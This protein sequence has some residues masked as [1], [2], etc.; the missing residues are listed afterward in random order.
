MADLPDD[1]LVLAALRAWLERAVIGL[2]L[3]P[4]AKG[5]YVK[6]QIHYAVSHATSNAQALD[7]LRAELAALHAADAQTR[8]TTLLVFPGLWP[9]FLEFNAFLQ[10]AQRALRR[11]RLEGVLQ[12][13]SFHPFYQ[14]ADS[15]HDDPANNSNRAPYPTLHVLRED[16]IARAVESFADT[17]SI[18]ENNRRTLHRLGHAGW[19][20]LHLAPPR[21][22]PQNTQP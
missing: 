20:A 1:T 9:E 17:D 7:A 18:F 8:D 15:A 4:F 6:G 22:K 10:D 2:N 13:A 12:I 5:V 19:D 3:C 21:P 14:F 16:S 11:M